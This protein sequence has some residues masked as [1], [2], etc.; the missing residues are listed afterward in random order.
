[1]RLPGIF[2]GDGYIKIESRQH[3]G[4]PQCSGKYRKI[5][6]LSMPL[7]TCYIRIGPNVRI[8]F[9]WTYQAM[10]HE[11]L[12]IKNNRIDLSKVPGVGKELKVGIKGFWPIEAFM[13]SLN[14]ILFSVWLIAVNAGDLSTQWHH[15]L[16]CGSCSCPSIRLLH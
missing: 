6:C 10:V 5:A 16:R 7:L 13:L 2:R 15:M 4:H 3:P 9:Q 12:G 14:T 11:R 1:M 8:F